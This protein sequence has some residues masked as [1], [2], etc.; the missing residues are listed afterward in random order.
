MSLRTKVVGVVLGL[1]LML[2]TGI[3]LHLQVVKYT[4]ITLASAVWGS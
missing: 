1:G 3:V 2:A 4:A